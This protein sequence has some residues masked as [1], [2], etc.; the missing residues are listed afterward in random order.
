MRLNEQLTPSHCLPQDASRATLIGR[1]WIEGEGAVLVRVT[2]EGVHDISAAAPTMSDLLELPEPVAAVHAHTG[3]RLGDTA[4][5]LAN[6]AQDARDPALPW[7]LAPSDLQA[8]KATGVTFVNSVLE[9][10]IE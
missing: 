5:I 6:S 2:T 7:F 1:V 10:V 3:N 8:L 4:T 9:R